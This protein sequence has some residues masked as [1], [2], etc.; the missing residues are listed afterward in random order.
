MP[1]NANAEDAVKPLGARLATSEDIPRAVEFLINFVIRWTLFF[2]S[3]LF[4]LLALVAVL[5]GW[6]WWVLIPAAAL[7][8]G[9]FVIAWSTKPRGRFVTDAHGPII[10]VPRASGEP[11]GKELK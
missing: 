9:S 1:E 8:L 4:G 7:S 10:V 5:R 2:F 3:G 11:S 6:A